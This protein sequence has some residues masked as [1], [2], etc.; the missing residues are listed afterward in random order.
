MLPGPSVSAGP[1]VQNRVREGGRGISA[2]REA[3]LNWKSKNPGSAALRTVTLPLCPRWELGPV[4]WGLEK[5][6]IQ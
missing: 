4:S 6:E 5:H 2:L 1:Q 3:T